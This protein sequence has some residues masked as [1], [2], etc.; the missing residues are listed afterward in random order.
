[1]NIKHNISETDIK[2]ILDSKQIFEFRWFFL[3]K[4]EQF[5]E[6]VLR[7]CKENW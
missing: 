7:W 1:V 6:I 2:N 4:F 5:I 3:G